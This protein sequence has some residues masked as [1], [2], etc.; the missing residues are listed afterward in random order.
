MAFS[1]MNVQPFP[2]TLQTFHCA[3]EI[4]PQVWIFLAKFDDFSS[5][6]EH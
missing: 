6:C 3:W 4:I 2:F 5:T 1:I